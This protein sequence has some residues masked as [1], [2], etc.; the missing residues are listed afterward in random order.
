MTAGAAADPRRPA[1]WIAGCIAGHRLV[2]GLA[3]DLD[4]AAARAGSRLPGW[5]RAHVLTHLARNADATAAMLAAAAAGRELDMYPGGD[6]GR[7]QSIRSGARGSVT[8]I[9]EDLA[10][11]HHRLEAVWASAPTRAWAVVGEP[12]DVPV[13][14]ADFA[15]H[16]WREVALHSVDLGADGGPGWPDLPAA[17]LEEEWNRTLA[18]L[19]RRIPPGTVLV[20]APDDAPAR[21]FGAGSARCVV[22]GDRAH[23]LGWLVG[24]IERPDA[25]RLRAWPWP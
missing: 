11:A 20:L 1:A 9:V 18:T 14:M 2:E 13:T 3:R 15:F 17:Y 8:E 10:A 25:V 24:R 7:N 23:L 12:G 19:R 5:S 6:R 22:H 16:R 4:E 21:A